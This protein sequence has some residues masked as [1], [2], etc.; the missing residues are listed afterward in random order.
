MKVQEEKIRLEND[1][2]FGKISQEFKQLEEAMLQPLRTKL[3]ETSKK[4]ED[5]EKKCGE[6]EKRKEEYKKWFMDLK[7]KDDKN[8]QALANAGGE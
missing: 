6:I 5:S 1:S 4:L 8:K 2:H 3:S 7:R